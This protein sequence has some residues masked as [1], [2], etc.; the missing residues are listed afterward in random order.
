MAKFV[1]VPMK[2]GIGTN[3]EYR[4]LAAICQQMLR[5]RKIK[6]YITLF[7]LHFILIDFLQNFSERIIFDEN[8]E[9]SFS[10]KVAISLK[11]EQIND[12]IYDY[13]SQFSITM[14]QYWDQIYGK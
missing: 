11:N 2:C 7:C 8:L 3:V 12:Q 1:L 10:A 6:K 9:K 4:C 14:T 5:F 13:V